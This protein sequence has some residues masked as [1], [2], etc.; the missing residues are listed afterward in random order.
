M[1]AAR[2]D[3]NGD[4]LELFANGHY[5]AAAKLFEQM[6]RNG[7]P[8][9]YLHMLRSAE[10]AGD[11]NLCRDAKKLLLKAAATGDAASLFAAHLLF[12]QEVDEA[13]SQASRDFLAKSADA[14]YLPAMLQLADDYFAARH[15]GIEDAGAYVY[16]IRAAIER[17]SDAAVCSYAEFLLDRKQKLPE[18]LLRQLQCVHQYFH[19]RAMAALHRMARGK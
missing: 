3:L 6:A 12:R 14:G 9:A 4:P 7:E 5:H 18:D 2:D 15:T 16:W 17:G 13:D 8:S 19:A 1:D 10:L 11:E